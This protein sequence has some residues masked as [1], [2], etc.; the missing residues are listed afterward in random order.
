M[1]SQTGA[2]GTAVKTFE[3]L[4]EKIRASE[5]PYDLEK[6][7]QAYKVAEKAHEG[8]L[9]TSGDPYITHPLAVASILLDYCMDTDTICAALLHDTVEDTDVTLDELRKKFGED[10]ALMVDGVTKIGLVPLV[11]KEEQQA[12]NIRKILMAMSKDIRVI[13]IKLADRLHNMRTLAAR[14]PEKQRKTSLE[15]MNFYA[16]IAHRLGM[17]D[18]KEEMEDIAIH[19]LDPYG[20]KEVEEQIALHKEERDAFID[21]IKK[22]IR[23]RISDI[24][25]EPIIEGRVKSIYSIYKKVYVK[26]KRFDEIYDIYAVRVIVQSVIECYNVLGVIHDM[27]RPIPYRFKDYIATPK[28]NRYQSLHTTVIGREG[29]PFEVQIRTVEMHNTAQY[30]VAAHWKYKAGISGNVSGEK[31]FD[32]IRQL[33]ERQQEADDVEAIADAIKTDLSPDEVFVF[34][35]KGDVVALPT[36]A[37]VLDFAY[38]IHTQVGNKMTGAKVGGRMVSFDY[39]VHTGEIVEI[40]TSGSPNY[41]PNRNWIEIAKT[42]EAKSKIRSWFK[43]ECREEN[44]ERGREEL[45][46]EFKRNNI[47]ITPELL[48]TSASRQR[49]DSVD[50][51]YAAIGYGGVSMAK[52]VQRIKEDQLRN[53]KEQ[54]AIQAAAENPMESISEN[55]RRSR[56]KGII[57]EGMENCLVKFAQCC[58]PLP[59]DPIIGF[60]TRGFGVSIHKQDC[61]NVV[62]NRDDPENKDRWLKATWAGVEDSTYRATIDVI[63]E[64]RITIFADITTA[65]AANHIPLQEMNGHHLKNGN[66]DL[67][68]TVEIAGVE[69]LSNVMGRIQKIPGVISVERTGKQ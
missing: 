65:I 3:Q 40:L 69:Q 34:T 54:Q 12:E 47:A 30:G 44:I 59:G 28:P 37:T 22:R 36:G 20:C 29:I 68:V 13:I 26:N 32:W 52:I 63:A 53:H 43:K 8:Q 61:V 7:T 5:K 15:T 66:L 62:N 58:N 23:E 45:E 25:P 4:V 14:P 21:S 24:K 10:V 56:K 55:N 2:A 49:L 41:G 16:P 60:V 51:L 19:Y 57:I 11:S 35:P 18:V 38:H 27:F 6:I 64:D 50:D 33:L 67:V 9:R 42:T 31:R 39:V 17:S 46:R 48:Q 1:T